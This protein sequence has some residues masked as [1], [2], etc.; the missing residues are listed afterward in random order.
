[1]C[2]MRFPK[3]PL[4]DA[5]ENGHLEIMRVL[6]EAGADVNANEEERIG[7]TPLRD[8]ADKCSLAVATLLV[9]A[10]ATQG[11]LAGCS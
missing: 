11:F 10:G 9:D 8:V 2:S 6:L 4:H 1:M 7:N 3:T 5:A